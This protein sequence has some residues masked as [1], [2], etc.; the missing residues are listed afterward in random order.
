MAHAENLLVEHYNADQV[1][2]QLKTLWGIKAFRP[3]LRLA[4]L[5]LADYKEGYPDGPP[6]RRGPGLPPA[7][8]PSPN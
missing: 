8:L 2:I 3:R 1:A 4:E 6:Y 7:S 5:A